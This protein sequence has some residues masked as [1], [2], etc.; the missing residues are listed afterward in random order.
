MR[1]ANEQ[2]AQALRVM[3]VH[4]GHD[5]NN[6]TLVSFG[7][8][9]GLHVCDLADALNIKY[10]LVPAYAGVLS[11]FGLLVAPPGKEESQSYIKLINE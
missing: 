5:P 3:S 7:G 6:F 9:G 4:R 11:A 1:V 2:M 8:A 10:A